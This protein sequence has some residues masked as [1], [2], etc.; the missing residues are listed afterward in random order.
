MPVPGRIVA[1]GGAFG[2]REVHGEADD[3][4]DDEHRHDEDAEVVARRRA[5]G[6]ADAVLAQAVL[7][8][9]PQA[10]EQP[11]ET[12]RRKDRETAQPQRHEREPHSAPDRHG[13]HR[14]AGVSEQARDDHEA[15][16]RWRATI[17]AS[18]PEAM[19]RVGMEGGRPTW[20]RC[21]AGHRRRR[22]ARGAMLQPPRPP[23]PPPAVPR[24]AVRARRPGAR[25]AGDF[26]FE[27]EPGAWRSRRRPRSRSERCP[28]GG[29]RRHEVP[30]HR[31]DAEEQI[32]V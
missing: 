15:E 3:Q 7:S 20:R 19:P 2:E 1:P 12:A 17:D 14:A 31:Q 8:E 25:A 30:L 21:R 28:Y 16:G 29:L 18:R 22:T 24:H 4:E 27:Q 32:A 5:L 13:E 9:G 26:G 6:E 11:R 23:A 10:D